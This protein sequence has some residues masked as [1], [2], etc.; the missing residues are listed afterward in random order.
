MSLAP[1]AFSKNPVPMPITVLRTVARLATQD[2]EPVARRR[3]GRTT[4]AASGRTREYLPRAEVD[5]L[6]AAARKRD[7]YRTRDAL[8]PS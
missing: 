6:I 4:N 7:R 5:R 1:S 8:S 3:P 2:G